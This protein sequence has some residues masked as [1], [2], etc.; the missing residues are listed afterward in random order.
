L[1]FTEDELWQHW[2]LFHGNE[3][4]MSDCPIC[5]ENKQEMNKDHRKGFFGHLQ[6]EHGPISRSRMEPEISNNPTYSYS[7]IVVQ[8]SKNEFL[9]VKEGYGAGWWLPGGH[10]DPGE[11]FFQA[12]LRETKEEGGIDVKLNG[13]LSFQYWPHPKGGAKQ[14]CIFYANPKD[15]NAPLK[16]IPDFESLES[17]WISF[18][19]LMNEIKS[20][21]M[22]LRGKEPI[23]WFGY[24]EKGGKIHDMSVLQPNYELD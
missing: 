2:P 10:V 16:K 17:K 1:G 3:H 23:E 21:K 19:D 20:G 6:K 22:K 12:A 11:T 15:E 14:R 13:I 24:V 7:L 8:N 4:N 5:I 18:E 9:I